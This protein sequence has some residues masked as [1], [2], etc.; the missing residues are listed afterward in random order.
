MPRVA[1]VL[2]GVVVLYHGVDDVAVDPTRYIS[3]PVAL[4]CFEEQ[5]RWLRD[6]FDIVP[7]RELLERVERRMRPSRIPV[8]VTFDDDLES[9]RHIAKPVLER[10]GV[11]ATFFLMGA[12]L[13]RPASTWWERVERAADQGVPL[14]RLLAGLEPR[15]D[16]LLAREE[17]TVADLGAIAYLTPDARRTASERLAGALGVDPGS[18]GMRAEDVRAIVDAG[19]DVGFHTRRHDVLPALDDPGLTRAMSDGRRELEEIVGRRLE[20]IAYPHGKADQRVAAAAREAEFLVGFV[21][22][23]RAVTPAS[24]PLLLD[25]VV[26]PLGGASELERLIFR[27]LR[28]AARAELAGARAG[29]RWITA[30][31]PRLSATAT[32]R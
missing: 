8:A 26:A 3:P 6:H 23:N 30:P 20:I 14:R 1:P 24:D 25:R 28:Q 12:S 22:H 10:L 13:A 15:L 7:A 17:T 9:H 27:S 11:P 16:A 2:G 32:S 18:A 29:R 21:A 19:F 31:F 5:L 4:A